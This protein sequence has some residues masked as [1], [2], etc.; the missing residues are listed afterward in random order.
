VSDPSLIPEPGELAKLGSAGGVGGL[1]TLLI[2]RMFGGQDKVLARLDVLQAG[3]SQLS[4]QLAVLASGTERRD[5]DVARLETTVAEQG[6]SIARLEAL[7]EQ[8]S[9]GL[10]R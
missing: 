3:V 1:L 5:H 6:K 10:I 2:G 8:I 4:Q 7:V 9:E